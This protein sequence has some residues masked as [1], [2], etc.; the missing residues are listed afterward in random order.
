MKKPLLIFFVLLFLGAM[1]LIGE[2]PKYN[3]FNEEQNTTT[4]VVPSSEVIKNEI[5]KEDEKIGEE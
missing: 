3:P 1:F 2:N 5:K 4:K